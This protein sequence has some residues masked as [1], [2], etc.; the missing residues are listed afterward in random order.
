MLQSG[1]S[2]D[3]IAL[4]NGL[5][6]ACVASAERDQYISYASLG[7]TLGPMSNAM[8]DGWAYTVLALLAVLS[9][10]GPLAGMKYGIE[11]RKARQ[12]KLEK[13]QRAGQ[14]RRAEK[15]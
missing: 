1:R 13:K 9:L 6:G 8:S 5:V 2:S 12:E 11:W 4:A 15:R 7:S 3:T 10:A 14:A